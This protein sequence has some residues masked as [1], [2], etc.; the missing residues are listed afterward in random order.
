MLTRPS[1]SI[2]DEHHKN[3]LFC[4]GLDGSV[5]RLT[6]ER[7]RPVAKSGYAVETPSSVWPHETQGC[8]QPAWRRGVVA[9]WGTRPSL[10]HAATDCLAERGCASGLVGLCGRLPAGDPRSRIR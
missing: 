8:P 5:N 3:A 2:C 4:A 9:G 6:L 1:P 10:V 7:V